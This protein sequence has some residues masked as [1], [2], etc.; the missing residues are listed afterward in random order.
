MACNLD[1][2]DGMLAS[3]A[4]QT[5]D[6]VKFLLCKN[7]KDRPTAEEALRHPWFDQERAAIEASIEIN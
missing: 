5:I 2:I 1:H 3:Q 7:P 4:P 6:L